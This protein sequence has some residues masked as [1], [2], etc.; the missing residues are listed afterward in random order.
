MNFVVFVHL[1]SI[2]TGMT[3]GSGGGRMMRMTR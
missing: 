2:N 1:T 3:A